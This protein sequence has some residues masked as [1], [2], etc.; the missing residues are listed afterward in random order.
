MATSTTYQPYYRPHGTTTWTP[1]GSPVTTLSE[2][3][4]GLSGNYDFQIV[5]TLPNGT[6]VTSNIVS[7]STAAQTVVRDSAHYPGAD[8]RYYTLPLQ[9]T[10]KWI[11]SGPMITALRQGTPNVRQPPNFCVPWVV[12]D[13]GDPD[14]TITD[15]SNTITAKVPVGTVAENK[16]TG[17][18][19][20]GGTDRTR[21][22]LGWTGNG[23]LIDGASGNAVQ[24]GNV[25]PLTDGVS[26]T[27]AQVNAIAS[28][29]N[30]QQVAEVPA[31]E[32][33][34]GTCYPQNFLI[35]DVIIATAPHVQLTGTIGSLTDLNGNVWSLV[36]G[37]SFQ[38]NSPAWWWGGIKLNGGTVSLKSD[39][40]D[41]YGGYFIALRKTN[42]GHVWVQ[43]AKQGGWWDLTTAQATP[44]DFANFTRP[45][46]G[47]VNGGGP[48]PGPGPNNVNGNS[49]ITCTLGMQVY[50]TTGPVMEDAT[51]E[52]TFSGASDNAIGNLPEFELQAALADPN[53]VPPHTVLGSLDFSQV[54]SN[55]HVWPIVSTD[56]GNTGPIPEGVTLGI[57][58]TTPRPTGMNRGQALLWD[59]F[60]QK[61]VLIY[62]VNGSGACSLE[63]Y[64]VSS[65]TIALSNQM[66][67]AF[68]AV[69]QSVGILAFDGS[70]GSQTGPSTAKGMV[71]GQRADAFPAPALIDL[72]ATGGSHVL[73]S[74]FGAWYATGLGNFYNVRGGSP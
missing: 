49:V 44:G 35:G 68:P 13:V 30:T 27:Q 19:S 47:G 62:N 23:I 59:I 29:I 60:Q 73:P 57:P 45:V 48:S 52:M 4:T 54:N 8:G 10:A 1:F 50:D 51:T 40:S 61:G 25:P 34:S 17:D 18:D 74:S 64:P 72:S 11:T 70:T 9:T 33:F 2:A 38:T 14:V 32:C 12:G 41:G 21:K 36:A 42:N 24:S 65:A 71:N 43:E 26:L 66:N 22:Y 39:G 67:A 20:L 69:M 6:Q 3:I 16:D 58:N 5:A 53:Y 7:D 46:P 63:T 37:V 31:G 15:G 56:T 55:A 28:A